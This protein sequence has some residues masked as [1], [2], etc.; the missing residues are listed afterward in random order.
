MSTPEFLG[1]Y[2]LGETLG[3]G[4]MGSVFRGKH[5]KTGEEVAVKLIAAHV[6][7]DIKFRRRFDAEIGTLK[8]LRHEN[9]VQLIGYGE[10]DGQLFYSMELVDG[11]PLGKRVRREK[12]LGWMTTIDISIQ[13]C[14]ALKHAHDF[15]VIHRD[16]KPAN[17]ILTSQDKVKLVDFG[18]A[19]IFGASEQT[20]AG[21]VMGT[22]DYMAPEQAMGDGVTLRSDLYALGSVMYAMTAG[23]APFKGKKITE[24]IAALKRDN[25]IP[26]ELIVP[27]T[28]EALV[29]LIH[30]LL[31]KDPVDRPPTALAVMNR[32]KAMRNGLIREQTINQER[33]NTRAR[34]QSDVVDPPVESS[35]STSDTSIHGSKGTSVSGVEFRPTP[36]GKLTTSPEKPAAP[37]ASPEVDH[38]AGTIKQISASHADATIV[39]RKVDLPG[40]IGSKISSSRRGTASDVGDESTD[41][42]AERS[43]HFQTVDSS[44]SESGIFQH[45]SEAASRLTQVLSAVVIVGLLVLGGLVVAYAL[46]KPSADDLF[47]QIIATTSTGKLSDARPQIDQFLK[48]YSDDDRGDD[49]R[50][51]DMSLRRDAVIRRLQLQSKL[52]SRKLDPHEQAFLEAMELRDVDTLAAQKKLQ[53]WLDV[54]VDSTTHANDSRKQ[55]AE[56]VEFEKQRLGHQAPLL[57]NDNRNRELL[58]RIRTADELAPQERTALLQGIIDLYSNSDWAAPAVKLARDRLDDSPP[59]GTKSP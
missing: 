13:I 24:V 31:E 36:V 47:N 5:A 28:P 18:I 34:G 27:E 44:P 38:E 1:P 4:G 43:T 39:A 57:G 12:R 29:E 42:I 59:P 15:G 52:P 58:D 7:D 55:I 54:F 8:R 56:L 49:V 20:M 40:N 23:R 19:K 11:E 45:T 2:R 30:H 17:L 32:L 41:P 3:R 9:I 35:F 51:M 25:P 53:Q 14:A 16:L 46:R 26:L 21:S 6:A 10:E 48:L 33:E 22:A 50:A 37:P